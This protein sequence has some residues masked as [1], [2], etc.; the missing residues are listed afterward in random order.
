MRPRVFPAENVGAA[1]EYDRTPAGFNEAAGIPR[2]KLGVAL[3]AHPG[4][5]ASM[6]PRVFPAEN[7][8]RPH[9]SRTNLD[10]SMRP[11]VFPAENDVTIEVANAALSLLQ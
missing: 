5:A 9:V 3:G 8:R 10:A 4:R 6:R 11:R 2:G 7:R 1:V